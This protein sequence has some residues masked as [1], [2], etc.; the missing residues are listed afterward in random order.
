MGRKHEQAFREEG[1]RTAN[2]RIKM[3]GIAVIRAHQSQLTSHARSEQTV[4]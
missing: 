3:L 4:Y 2:R 1:T